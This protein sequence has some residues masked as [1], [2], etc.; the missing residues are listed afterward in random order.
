[1]PAILNH[2]EQ[3]PPPSM[4]LQQ[5]YRPRQHIIR[6]ALAC[7][8]AALQG[9]TNAGLQTDI[10][11]AVA[12]Q[13][14]ANETIGHSTQPEQV[15]PVAVLAEPE[16]AAMQAALAP[17]PEPIVITDLWQHLRRDMHWSLHTEQPR[18]QQEIRWLQRHPNY[19]LRLRERLQNY[20]PY[21]YREVQLRDMPAE[22]ALLP[23]VESAFDVYAFSHGGAAG[24][25]QFIRGTARQ[26]GLQLNDWYDGRRD[27]VASTD[28]ALSYLQDLHGRFDDWHLA[29]AGY[30]AGAGNVRKALRKKPGGNYFELPLPR[31]TRHYVP[32]LLAFVAVVQDPDQYGLELP[33]LDIEPRFHVL[34]T[35]GQ[36]QLDKLAAAA[37][38]SMKT[39]RF[40]NPALSRWATSPDGP[41]H[42]ILPASVD[43]ASAQQ[44]VAAINPAKRM[45]WQEITVRSGDTLSEL[46]ARYHA[47][48]ATL[49]QANRLRNNHIRAGKTLLIPLAGQA[50]APL[51]TSG[52]ATHKVAAGDSL[53]KI[54]REYNI[55]L[56]SLM[57]ANHV[58]PKDPL[59]V[60]KT[61]VLPGHTLSGQIGG[62]TNA[63]QVV[64]TVR[65]KVRAGDSLSRIAGRF[66]VTVAQIVRWNRLDT[67]RYLQPGQGLLLHVNVVGG[68]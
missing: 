58:G 24:P 12:P 54:A 63:E 32:R 1:M 50:T 66:N 8:V 7:S 42:V 65:Y 11:P 62:Q 56:N 49:R 21:V 60:G 68:N 30:N 9:C 27:I 23:I 16:P 19:L 39:F 57:K 55:S 3:N 51:Q 38:L 4:F 15:K 14:I 64:R 5:F 28:A 46:A 48:V 22:L 40:W 17:E 52:T 41:H 20:L 45:D 29:L 18:V 10:P 31:E 34:E 47:D 35:E 53:W 36:F 13:N 61:L 26:Y 59:P 43:L 6:I 2:Y 37:D 33:E 25:W 44:T 67:K